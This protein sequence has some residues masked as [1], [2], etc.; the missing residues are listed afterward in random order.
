MIIKKFLII[1]LMTILLLTIGRI[2]FYYEIL[3]WIVEKKKERKKRHVS[4][5][6]NL[7]GSN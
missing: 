7:A 2:G 3:V 1:K 5:F 6:F 4:S